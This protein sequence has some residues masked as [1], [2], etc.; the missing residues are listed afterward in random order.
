MTALRSAC[1]YLADRSERNVG[2]DEL[3]AAGM[4][5]FRLVRLFL[6]RSRQPPHAFLPG[7][8]IHAARRLLEAGWSIAASTP[9]TGFADQA[10][11]TAPSA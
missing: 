5:K 1:D 6:A 9:A 10:T 4:G 2:L 11:F 3:A 7:S 8:P